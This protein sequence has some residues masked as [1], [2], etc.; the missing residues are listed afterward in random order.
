MPLPSKIAI[1]LLIVFGLYVGLDYLVQRLVLIPSYIELE[2]EGARKDMARLGAALK[3][4]QDQLVRLCVDWAQWDDTYDFA[5]TRSAKYVAAN[6]RAD[7]FKDNDVDLICVYDVLGELVWG[8]IHD[9]RGGKPLPI[10]GYPVPRFSPRHRL[11]NP[12][13]MLGRTAG[14]VL[15]AHAPLLLA[16]IPIVTSASTGPSRGALMMGRFLDTGRLAAL[17]ERTIVPFHLW[18]ARGGKVPPGERWVLDRLTPGGRPLIVIHSPR[19]LWVYRLLPDLAGA[20]ALLLRAEVDRDIYARGQVTTRYM[21]FSA[22]SIAVLAT[23]MTSLLLRA[24]VVRPIAALRDQV[25]VI[26]TAT[27][28]ATPLPV[29]RED[30]IGALA[31]DFNRMLERLWEARAKLLEQSADLQAVNQRL[32]ADIAPR[33]QVEAKLKSHQER[34]QSLASQLTLAEERERRRLAANLHDHVGQ[35]LAVAKITLH[36][37]RE[38]VSDPDEYARLDRVLTLIDQTIKDTRSL[39][40][41]LSP[42]VLHE[43]GLGAALQWLCERVRRHGIICEMREDEGDRTLADDVSLTLFTAVRE[44]LHNVV[45]HADCSHTEVS[46]RTQEGVVVIEVAD[47]GI[48]FEPSQELGEAD[49]ERGFGLFS[50]HERLESLGG[51][52]HIASRL[53]AGT[54]VTLSM[55]LN[56]RPTIRNERTDGDGGPGPDRG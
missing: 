35:A 30:E 14:I 43:L 8:Q 52:V 12:G 26:G 32:Q 25:A 24:T 56:A 54:R 3:A 21:L 46:L 20:G 13:N 50:I 6:L 31:R 29:E 7:T 16:S 45:K 23:L 15:T 9:A 47:D 37:L 34:L 28:P 48:G 53:G 40:F 44:L 33:R 42:P 5:R 36:G 49:T 18:A 4:E 51:S 38:D 55:P 1:I 22:I 39:T 10:P 41:E 17:R 11:M 19:A 2:Q 27:D